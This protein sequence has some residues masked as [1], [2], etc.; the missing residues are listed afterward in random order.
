MPRSLSYLVKQN[1]DYG[2]ALGA[3]RGGR[4]LWPMLHLFLWHPGLQVKKFR[5]LLCCSLSVLSILL[6]WWLPPAL[7]GARAAHL[8]G[9]RLVLCLAHGGLPRGDGFSGHLHCAALVVLGEPRKRTGG[10]LLREACEQG[11]C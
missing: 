7:R 3:L 10:G 9:R 8:R 11:A 2:R 1:G 5:L 6:S 4:A